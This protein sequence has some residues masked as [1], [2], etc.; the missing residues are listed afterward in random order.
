[1]GKIFRSSIAHGRIKHIDVSA[2]QALGGVHRVVTGEDVRKIIP[3]P[4]YGPSHPGYTMDEVE[5]AFPGALALYADACG[6]N[7][8]WIPLGMSDKLAECK[9]RGHELAQ[10]VIGIAAA[11]IVNILIANSG[12]VDRR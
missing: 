11:G 7:Q 5:A 9:R 3:D 4:Y 1:M 8:N 10:T 6:G 12:G 2:A